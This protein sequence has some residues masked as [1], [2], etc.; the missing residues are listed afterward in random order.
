M[1]QKKHSSYRGLAVFT[2]LPLVLL[3]LFFLLKDDR[4]R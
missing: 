1:E 3:G 2:L 4:T